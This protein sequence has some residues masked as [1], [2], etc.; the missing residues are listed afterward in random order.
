MTKFI[1]ALLIFAPM[2]DARPLLV[3][4]MPHAGTRYI[5]NTLIK[6]FTPPIWTGP[7][8]R[9]GDISKQDVQR[10]IECSNSVEF[11]FVHHFNNIPFHLVETFSQHNLSVVFVPRDP[12]ESAVSDAIE[13][14]CF[15]K[16]TRNILSFEE[17]EKL[18]DEKRDEILARLNARW[19]TFILHRV[20]TLRDWK[21]Y[22]TA[23][24]KTVSIIPFTSLKY[25]NE[26]FWFTL[27]EA[28]GYS[29][30]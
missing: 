26:T 27:F 1:C 25:E 14:V 18:V 15:P 17:Q 5:Q 4:T 2:L 23:F 11:P 3:N 21:R 28:F 16:S 19:R 6:Y 8:L 13:H 30:T 12:R 24:P 20:R 22:K 7:K 9:K 29:K 10:I